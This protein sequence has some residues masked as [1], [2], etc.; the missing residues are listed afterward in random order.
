MN[1]LIP[2][3]IRDR[4]LGGVV[5]TW[6][7]LALCSMGQAQQNDPVQAG[8]DALKSENFPWYN[9]DS[10]TARIM[11]PSNTQSAASAK[12]GSVTARAKRPPTT[13]TTW[14]GWLKGFFN[15][16]SY[17]SY[18]L[19]GLL[20]LLIFGL[21]VWGLTRRRPDASVKNQRS[22]GAEDDSIIKRIEELP[23]QMQPQIDS[24]FEGRAQAAAKAGN[25][26]EAVMLLFSFL[27]LN[28]DRKGLIHLQRGTT[29]RQYLQQIYHQDH[30]PDFF[31]QLM[32][33]FE[34]SF[35]GGHTIDQKTFEKCWSNMESAKQRL[36]QVAGGER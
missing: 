3:I 13:P 6:L 10:N 23:F 26:S 17:L 29:N 7:W 30:L 14:G 21:L 36:G 12:R 18:L 19:I 32:E 1:E 27:L 34:K 28:L 4:S 9:S 2:S 33:P 5:L 20:G 35:F 11:E 24:D 25:Y 8:A 15:Q 22:Q 16:L 31:V